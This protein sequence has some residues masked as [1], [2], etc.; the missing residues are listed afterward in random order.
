MI[1]TRL[2]VRYG[3]VIL[4]NTQRSIKLKDHVDYLYMQI[5][6]HVCLLICI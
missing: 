5:Y 6:K 1:T 3:I 4:K 2:N